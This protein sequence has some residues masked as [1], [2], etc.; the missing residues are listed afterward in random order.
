MVATGYLIAMAP[1]RLRF[2][3]RIKTIVIDDVVFNLHYRVTSMIF[4]VFSVLT[5]CN[6]FFGNPIDC[7]KGGD[8]PTPVVNT[9]CWIE[10]TFTIPRGLTKA[11]D[12]EV[13]YPGIEKYDKFLDDDEVI[14][15][16][17]YQWVAMVLFFQCISFFITHFLWKGWEK[18]R[19]QTICKDLYKPI[20]PEDT[21]T[22]CEKTLLK[23]IHDTRY[24]NTGYARKY[25]IC[26]VINFLHVLLQFWITDVFL[27][28]EFF[29]YGLRIMDFVQDDPNARV[30]PMVRVFP[31]MAKCTFQRFGASGSLQRYDNLCILPLNIVN[32]KGYAI[33]WFWLFFLGVVSALQLIHR[34]SLLLFESYRWKMLTAFNQIISN[35]LFDRLQARSTYG[36]W[37]L[38]HM[39]SKNVNPIHFR[40]IVDALAND[41]ECYPPAHSKASTRE[42]SEK[43]LNTEV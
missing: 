14:E 36:D 42:S 15:H 25:V 21:K 17:Y 43:E 31:K 20:I 27:D 23:H 24:Q 29:S 5:T 35:K 12:T 9:F 7:I 2:L 41:T 28:G 33:I 1:V 30:D 3:G 32:E 6:Q 22:G 10:G 34:A 39:L 4:L 37:F 8:V 11:I 38:L 40:D 16:K 26:E 13:A 19:L 18:K